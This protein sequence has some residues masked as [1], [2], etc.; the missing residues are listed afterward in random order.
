MNPSAKLEI[1]LPPETL[2]L[3][4]DAM[5]TA[6]CIT[7]AEAGSGVV[8]NI[9][10]NYDYTKALSKIIIEGDINLFNKKLDE[11]FGA[12]KLKPS[13]YITIDNWSYFANKDILNLRMGGEKFPPPHMTIGRNIAKIIRRQCYLFAKGYKYVS[14]REE[15]AGPKP[16]KGYLKIGLDNS[17]VNLLYKVLRSSSKTVNIMGTQYTITLLVSEPPNTVEKAF[18]V[19]RNFYKVNY[20]KGVTINLN[21]DMIKYILPHG[22]LDLLLNAPDIIYHNLTLNLVRE[23]I[24]KTID[25]SN[26]PSL[27]I[28]IFS[29]SMFDE[30]KNIVAYFTCDSIYLQELYSIITKIHGI[31]KAK[32][33]IYHLNR[34]IQY[35]GE[36]VQKAHASKELTIVETLIPHIRIFMNNLISGAPYADSLY[37]VM[38]IL[39]ELER[40]DDK[41][42]LMAEE[43]SEAIL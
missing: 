9:S 1:P 7:I 4:H 38:R 37:T 8:S 27:S 28:Y 14:I 21:D 20:E 34:A 24:Q 3:F 10:I 35:L 2:L 42:K 15:L 41:F 43:L 39:R 12:A 26:L 29:G 31:D 36:I 5:C 22:S 19:S 11:L 6:L 18:V 33:L 32:Y 16:S 25:I 13:S 17:I 30:N 40:V 23:Y